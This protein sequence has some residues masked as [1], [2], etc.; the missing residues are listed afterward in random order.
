M[1]G[2]MPSTGPISFSDFAAVYGG[3][4]PHSMNEYYKG[5]ALVQNNAGNTNVPTSGAISMSQ[6]RGQGN[7]T[8]VLTPNPAQQDDFLFEPAPGSKTVTTGCTASGVNVTSGSWSWVSGDVFT[9]NSPNSLSTNFQISVGKNNA[10][11]AVYR[12]TANNGLNATVDVICSYST[13]L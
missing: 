1:A 4:Q 8:L 9:L 7:A 5:G 6:F 2:L 12:F 10:K 13:D 11:S 3:S